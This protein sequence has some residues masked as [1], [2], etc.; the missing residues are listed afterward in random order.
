MRKGWIV[1]GH[2]GSGRTLVV[3]SGRRPFS[4]RGPTYYLNEI[5]YRPAHVFGTRPAAERARAYINNFYEV[6]D[7]SIEEAS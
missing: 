7:T 5:S 2:T 6:V 4:N 1:K 3:T